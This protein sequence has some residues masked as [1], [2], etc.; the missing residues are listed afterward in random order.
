VTDY[1]IARGQELEPLFAF[2]AMDECAARSWRVSATAK[3]R[4]LLGEMP[5]A[6]PLKTE[7]LE[8]IDLGDVRLER[9]V[10]DADAR[11]T[12]PANVLIP[13][14][15]GDRL[16]AVLCFHGRDGDKNIVAG[17][18]DAEEN[19]QFGRL[20]TQYGFLTITFDLRCFGERA[21]DTIPMFG[22]DPCDVHF[23]RGSL[24]GI[25]LLALNVHD[26]IRTLDY[27]DSREDVDPK[28]IGCCGYELGGMMALWTSALDRRIKAS[29]SGACLYSFD[30][31]AVRQGR[32]CGAM[33]V[34]ALRRY[35]EMED[36]A[37][38]TAPRSLMIQ[39]ATDDPEKPL[40]SSKKCYAKLRK[41]FN[42]WGR[43]DHVAWAACEKKLGFDVNRA[44]EWFRKWL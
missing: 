8:T 31:F 16:P 4:D 13:K 21:D 38:L 17:V 9:I 28:R 5:A 19:G 40:E 20:L 7:V 12:V 6:V 10:F 34:P 11:S 35:F 39:A 29:V 3:A 36:I 43:P 18:T 15:S 26:A 14:H 30:E 22:R 2:D 23:A 24:L 42:V 44:A 1:L 33:F 25:N 27:L 41:V 32:F 37:A